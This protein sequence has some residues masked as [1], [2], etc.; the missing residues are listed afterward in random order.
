[1]FDL[2]SIVIYVG[3]AIIVFFLAAYAEKIESK[4]AVWVIIVILS[5]LA[6]LRNVSVG[7]DTKTY[8]NYF[9]LISEG[10]TQYV[11]GLEKSFVYICSLLLKIW[12]NHQFLLTLFALITHGLVI[13]RFWK[14]RELCS[15]KWAVFSYYILYFAFSLNGMR[16]SIAVAIVFYA[17][18]FL[19]QGKYAK[20]IISTLIA[21]L[22]HFTSIISLSYLLFE[23]I[24]VKFYD[25]NRKI[26]SFVFSSIGVVALIIV[27]TELLN[28]YLRYFTNVYISIGYMVFAKLALLLLSIFLIKKGNDES[29]KAFVLSCR[30]YYFLG[31]ILNF[32]SY[33][34]LYAGRVGQYYYIFETI[35]I[36]YIF[37]EKNNSIEILL[38]KFCNLFLLLFYLFDGLASG[39]QGEIPYR[40]FWQN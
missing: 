39:S 34:F 30:W 3:V 20:F 13:F 14:D 4:K 24:L 1:M 22:F 10:Q 9:S 37:K 36:G 38:L 18:Y 33:I 28:R 21:S 27:A 15:F 2:Q 32:L 5:L 35:Y 40:F 11:Y 29:K 25:S 6:G 7:I 16:Q 17:T 31:L 19:R 8:L 12:N 26:K 23:I